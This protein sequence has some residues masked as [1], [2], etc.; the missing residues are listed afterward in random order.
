MSEPT[1]TLT[2]SATRHTAT[3]PVVSGSMGAPAIDVGKLNR[4]TG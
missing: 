2:D 4:E 1:V 3:L